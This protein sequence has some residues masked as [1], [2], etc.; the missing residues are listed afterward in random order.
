MIGR[1]WGSA[2]WNWHEQPRLVAL[3]ATPAGRAVIVV[4]VAA[5]VPRYTALVV[6][7]ALALFALLPARRIEILAAAAVAVLALKVPPAVRDAGTLPMLL[8]MLALVALLYLVYRAACEFQRLPAWFRR[9]PFVLVHLLV[10]GLA[11]A[12][13]QMPPAAPE[14]NFAA[15]TAAGVAAVVPFVLWRAAYLMQSGRSG[16]ARKTRFIDHWFYAFPAWGGSMVP[17][18]KGYEYLMQHRA[19]GREAIGAAQL[20]GIKLL[21]LALLWGALGTLLQ[22]VVHGQPLP[23][24]AHGIEIANLDWPRLA[25]LIADGPDAAPLA[26]RW[27]VL[28]L[29]LVEVTL[30]IAATGH[31]VI[32]LLRLF[33]FRVFRNTYRPLLATSIV[34]FWNRLYYYFKEL[35]VQFFFFPAYLRWFKKSPRLRIFTAVMLSACVGNL[36]FHVVRDI[37][38]YAGQGLQ[39]CAAMLASRGLYCLLLGLGI[40]VSMLREQQRRGKA[41]TP[42][43]WTPWGNARRIAGV[44][45][46]YSL[47]HIWNV[48]SP[49]LD[50]WHRTDFFLGLFGLG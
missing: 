21:L 10:L 1:G 47:I 30:K 46:F 11:G 13:A 45:L 25:A 29:E 48:G 20:A 43:R 38:I 14:G 6:V 39:A 26:V 34:E 37:H 5:L 18:G 35:L 49:R 40:F 19:D 17:Y 8:T 16:A 44:W 15:W 50:F 9:S 22:A 28:V 31:L 3:A 23:A 27:A 36:Y 7:P 4:L 41:V 24:S 33:G 2:A 12:M 32:G 42:T